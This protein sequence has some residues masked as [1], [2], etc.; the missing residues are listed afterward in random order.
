M[1]TLFLHDGLLA[2]GHWRLITEG[3]FPASALSQFAGWH[4]HPSLFIDL[5]VETIMRNLLA[6]SSDAFEGAPTCYHRSQRINIQDG[7]CWAV[8]RARW[9]C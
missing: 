5:L 2:A 3:L 6:E 9:T 1:T 4:R 7:R 8:T